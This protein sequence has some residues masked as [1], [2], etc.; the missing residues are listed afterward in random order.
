[1]EPVVAGAQIAVKSLAPGLRVLPLSIVTVQFVTEP[2][3]LRNDKAQSRIVDLEI[4]RQSWE[5]KAVS[6]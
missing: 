4:T 6:S 5:I 3:F 2:H 1:M